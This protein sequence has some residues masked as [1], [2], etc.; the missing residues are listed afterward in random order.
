MN[1]TYNSTLKGFSQELRKE[2][3]KEERH[4]WYDFLK[5]Q[6]MTVNRQKIV[7]SYILDFYIASAKVAIELDGAQHY[8]TD[9]KDS[10]KERDEFLSNNGITVLRYSNHDINTNFEGVCNDINKHLQ[11]GK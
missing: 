2:M 9:G 4:L 1:E 6:P 8:T 11:G 7:G 5:K 3:T 10:D